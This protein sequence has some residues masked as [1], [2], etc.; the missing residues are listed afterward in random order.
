MA[1]AASVLKQAKKIDQKSSTRI[2]GKMGNDYFMPGAKVYPH[3]HIGGNFVVYSKQDGH[4]AD[5]IRG[6]K[7]NTDTIREAIKNPNN[8]QRPG[9]KE[10]LE[11]IDKN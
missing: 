4:H 7:E 3:I 2:L 10:L 6:D 1:N 8:A 9:V 5:L 11:W